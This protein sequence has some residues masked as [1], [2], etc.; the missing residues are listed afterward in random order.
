MSF[1]TLRVNLLAARLTSLPASV[2]EARNIPLGRYRGLRFGLALSPY[3]APEVFAEGA[4]MRLEPLSRDFQGPRA[5]L[6]AVE[7]LIGS[8]D[9]QCATARKNLT[10]AQDQ[11]RDYQARLGGPFPHDTYLMEL[12]GLRDQLKAA[13][14]I[15]AP[16]PAAKPLPPAH[17]LAEQ[18]KALK[19]AH[20]IEAPPQR[21]TARI[22][23]RAEEPIAARIRH[24]IKESPT[25]NPEEDTSL[26]AV[27]AQPSRRAASTAPT[28]PG[29]FEVRHPHA[30]AKPRTFHQEHA[31]PDERIP[32]RQMSL[33]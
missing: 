27:A 10:I 16:D 1:L 26:P 30:P 31:S 22:T 6:N 4:A 14:S 28:Q 11:R 2:H 19:A 13:L 18:I 29:L 9:A 25:I 21:L 7:R 15:T 32:K 33:F 24:R 23:A 20:T 5:I 17:E 3:S 12:T 8:N